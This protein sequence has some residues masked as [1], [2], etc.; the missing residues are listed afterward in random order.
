M[1]SEYLKKIEELEKRIS[2]LEKRVA[3][4]Q[5]DIYVTDEEMGLESSNGCSGCQ[6]GCPLN[7]K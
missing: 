6:G 5:E 7:N 3:F 4:I 2:D 1:E